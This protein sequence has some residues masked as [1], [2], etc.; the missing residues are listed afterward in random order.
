MAREYL[1]TYLND[2]LAGAAAALELLEHVKSWYAGTQIEPFAAELHGDILADRK[3]LESLMERMGVGRSVA[4]RV[5]GWLAEKG[6]QLKLKLD[7][8]AAKGLRLLE[9]MDAL[10]IGIEGKRLLWAALATVAKEDPAFRG[11]DYDALQRRA[12]EQRERIEAM[13]LDAAR[14]CLTVAS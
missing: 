3:E 9:A 12:R 14:A 11:V 13:R 2:H 10:S 7:D 1:A 6:A 4:R 8:P 5:A